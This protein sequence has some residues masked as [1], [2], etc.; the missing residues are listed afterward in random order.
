MLEE[1][2]PIKRIAKPEEIAQVVS[3]LLSN[4]SSFIT[5]ALIAADGGYTC[6]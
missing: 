6:Q 1:A 2:Q 4:E 5:G 3:F